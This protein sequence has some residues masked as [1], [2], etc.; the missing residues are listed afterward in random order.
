MYSNRIKRAVALHAVAFNS[1]A[2]GSAAGGGIF[3]A[4][5]TL[6]LSNDL[7]ESNQAIGGA[8]AFVDRG[9]GVPGFGDG[10]GVD[11]GGGSLILND[12]VFKSNQAIGGIAI[13]AAPAA[14]RRGRR[15]RERW[16]S[17]SE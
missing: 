5:G 4:G 8:G 16:H 11:V 14:R 2:S 9:P 13:G 17:D 3:V 15:I 7:F 1:P 12:D 6:V 10:G